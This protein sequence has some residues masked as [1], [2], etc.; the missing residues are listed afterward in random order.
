MCKVW[1]VD[2]W[3]RGLTDSQSHGLIPESLEM[4]NLFLADWEHTSY[5]LAVLLSVA[6]NL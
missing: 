5:E 4:L 3:T 2:L 1:T 6:E